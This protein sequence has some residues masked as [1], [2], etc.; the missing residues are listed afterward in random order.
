MLILRKKSIYLGYYLTDKHI[1]PMTFKKSGFVVNDVVEVIQRLPP[2]NAHPVRKVLRIMEPKQNFFVSVDDWDNTDRTP[3]G[4]MNEVSK[5]LS[6][7]FEFW[8]ATN[9]TGWFIIRVE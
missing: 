7:K 5:E 1:K 4:M 2:G 6:R 9:N 3:Q 8:V